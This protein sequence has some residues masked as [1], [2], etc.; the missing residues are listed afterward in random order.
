MRNTRGDPAL[1]WS[2]TVFDEGAGY[3]VMYALPESANP[4]E[5]KRLRAIVE[6]TELTRLG[7]ISGQER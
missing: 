4:A 2:C 1:V 6:A 3:L 5:A 7:E